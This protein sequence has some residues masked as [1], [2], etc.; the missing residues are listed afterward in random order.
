MFSFRTSKIFYLVPAAI[1]ALSDA[2][3]ANTC[4]ESLFHVQS[5]TMFNR[6]NAVRV[7]SLYINSDSSSW[8]GKKFIYNNGIIEEVRADFKDEDHAPAFWTFYND[9][10]ETVLKKEGYEYLVSEEKKQDTL[11]YDI[12]TYYKGKFEYTQLIRIT[13]NYLSE[14]LIDSSFSELYEMFFRNDTLVES[15]T[16]DYNTDSSKKEERYYVADIDN[17]YKC[18]LY[19]KENNLLSSFLYKPNENGFSIINSLGDNYTETYVINVEQKTT[20]IRKT[21]KPVKIS[22]KARYFDLL[23]RYK[24]R[25]TP[26]TPRF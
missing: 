13:S 9:T 4:T 2:V 23:G 10:N 22:P 1:L 12:K 5:P 24:F 26:L 21:L 14:E 18:E 16:E 20:S 11:L 8:K 15:K 3:P 6:E 7:D 19:D 17:D 25:S